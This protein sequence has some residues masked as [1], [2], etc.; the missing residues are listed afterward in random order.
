MNSIEEF[1]VELHSNDEQRPLFVALRKILSAEH[2]VVVAS[3]ES[4]L[5]SWFGWDRPSVADW[6]TP[7][8]AP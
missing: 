6:E 8:M 3:V 7:G 2:D 5:G 4:P 1:N